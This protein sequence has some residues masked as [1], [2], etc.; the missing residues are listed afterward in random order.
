MNPNLPNN[1]DSLNDDV[2]STSSAASIAEGIFQNGASQESQEKPYIKY[3]LTFTDGS[4][5]DIETN[6]QMMHA[7]SGSYAI[8]RK[9]DGFEK[10]YIIMNLR[11][12][13]IVEAKIP[14]IKSSKIILP[15]GMTPEQFMAGQQLRRQE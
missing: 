2:K 7:Q 5:E 11:A 15:D 9:L 10:I 12:I 8:I 3:R 4:Q 1:P 13:D 6:N 14:Q